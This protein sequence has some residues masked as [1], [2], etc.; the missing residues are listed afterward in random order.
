LS[1]GRLARAAKNSVGNGQKACKDPGRPIE[2]SHR[3][4]GALH[5]YALSSIVREAYEGPNMGKASLGGAVSR[6]GFSGKFNIKLHD[7]ETPLRRRGPSGESGRGG[8]GGVKEGENESG[9]LT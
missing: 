5:W 9:P 1:Q 2:I 6:N 3:R 4:R 8:G 7:A